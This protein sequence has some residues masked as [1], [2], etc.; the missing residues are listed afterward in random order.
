M[1]SEKIFGDL[2]PGDLFRFDESP[3][4]ESGKHYIRM[5]SRCEFLRD[6]A[7]SEKR[8]FALETGSGIVSVI[9][10]GTRVFHVEREDVADRTQ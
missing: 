10:P 6:V 2:N 8:Y 3:E 1:A 5:D 4:T 7:E 9:G